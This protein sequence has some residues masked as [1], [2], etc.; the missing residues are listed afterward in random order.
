ME[1]VVSPA[2]WDRS[3]Q[4]AS[5]EATPIW[6]PEPIVNQEIDIDS[7]CDKAIDQLVAIPD[8][9]AKHRPRVNIAID[10]NSHGGALPPAVVPQFLRTPVDCEGKRAT[11]V[12]SAL[13]RR[14]SWACFAIH[15]TPDPA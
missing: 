13:A 11:R 12:K 14:R 1:D 5:W 10:E 9:P 3:N 15:L 6:Q 2:L 4:P 8:H 7:S